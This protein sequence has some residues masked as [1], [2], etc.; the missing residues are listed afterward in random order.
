MLGAGSEAEML[1][2][3]FSWPWPSLLKANFFSKESL[4]H[5]KIPKGV[6]QEEK[7]VTNPLENRCLCFLRRPGLVPNVTSKE[8]IDA[9]EQKISCYR[10]QNVKRA[11]VFRVSYNG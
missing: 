5:E 10:F 9:E 3:G 11:F 4:A 6:W 1:L 8:V 2:L 7:W